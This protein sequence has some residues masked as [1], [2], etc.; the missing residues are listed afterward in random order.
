M[1]CSA[2]FMSQALEERDHAHKF[3]DY[4]NLRGNVVTLQGV[5]PPEKQCWDS[6]LAAFTD[7]LQ[8]ESEVSKVRSC[9]L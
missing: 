7:A 5:L 4:L 8:L 3:I 1:G 6:P 9:M 2:F